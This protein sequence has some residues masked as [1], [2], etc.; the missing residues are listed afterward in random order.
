M[1]NAITEIGNRLAAMN[2]KPKEAED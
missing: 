1:K 2:T